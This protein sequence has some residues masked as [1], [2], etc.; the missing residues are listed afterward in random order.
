[1]EDLKQW[2]KKVGAIAVGG[3]AIYEAISHGLE[4]VAQGM[5]ITA[6]FHVVEPLKSIRH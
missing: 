5:A 1:L 2:L 6:G 4:N 3:S